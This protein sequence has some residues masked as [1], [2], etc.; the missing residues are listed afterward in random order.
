VPALLEGCTA[1]WPAQRAWTAQSLLMEREGNS[2]WVSE[3]RRCHSGNDEEQ[4]G[5][6][7]VKGIGSRDAY[8]FLIG[9][10]H[11]VCRVL[12]FSQVVGIGT[13]PTP[14]L[15]A[16]VPPPRFWG[17]GHTRWRE[18][19]WES[20]NSD[21][22]TYTVVLFIYTYFVAYDIS[23]VLSVHALL[24]LTVFLLLCFVDKNETQI[25]NLHVLN[26]LL[27]FIIPSVTLFRNS[28]VAILTLKMHSGRR[29]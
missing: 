20:A 1:G 7:L 23:Y 19:G 27:I 11:R 9:L 6:A 12:S 17:E 18:R 22:G 5:V 14:L 13:P 8:L 26:Y 15:Q 28:K 25:F 24:V 3:S 21:E 10:W 4:V 29:L 16:S 2:L